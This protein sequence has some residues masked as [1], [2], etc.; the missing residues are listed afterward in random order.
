MPSFSLL[1]G[2]PSCDEQLPVDDVVETYAFHQFIDLR[3]E[4]DGNSRQIGVPV[5]VANPGYIRELR[6]AG[7]D[8]P[9]LLAEIRGDV[10][11]LK[12]AWP[13]PSDSDPDL[14]ERVEI[15][16]V[17]EVITAGEVAVGN[18]R[19]SLAGL[20]DVAED[21]KAGRSV[22]G[23]FVDNNGRPAE[24]EL[25]PLVNS[26]CDLPQRIRFSA[27]D[28]AA[29][30]PAR[31]VVVPGLGA[32]KLDLSEDERAAAL[33]DGY[34]TARARLPDSATDH[35][36]LVEVAQPMVRRSAMTAADADG[37]IEAGMALARD[38][39]GAEETKQVLNRR[40]LL[41]VPIEQEWRLKGYAR[42]MLVNTFSL[43]PQEQLTLEVF[44]WDRRKTAS[45]TTSSQEQESSSESVATQK[46][47]RDALR[48]A[49]DTNG[50]T[51]GANLSVSVPQVGMSAGT[52]FSLSSQ[53]E[54]TRRTTVQSINEATEKA[55][56]RIKSSVQ[57][58]VSE[59]AEFGRED[60][61]TRRIVNPN[62]GRI[63]HFDAF[64]VLAGFDVTTRYR[65]D[66]AVLCVLYP[67]VDFLA[68][69]TDPE[70]KVRSTALLALEGIIYDLV[71][72]R[73]RGGF[74]AARTFLAW[75]RICQYACDAACTC[76]T[77]K[78]E[79]T[80]APAASG[81]AYEADVIAALAALR[82]VIA[83]L[84]GAS[85]VPLSQRVGI[86]AV[87]PGYL[88]ADPQTQADLRRDWQAY[89]FRQVV[90]E[91]V[92]SPFWN[93]CNDFAR[94]SADSLDWAGQIVRGASPQVSNFMNGAIAYGSLGVQVAAFLAEQ[95]VKFRA[96][97]PF[98]VPYAGFDSMGLEPAFQRLSSAYEKWQETEDAR[99][100]P[101]PP[102][103]GGEAPKA[104]GP[105]PRPRRS[106]Q[107]AYSA[108]ALAKA[109]VDVDALAAYLTL[110]RA[111]FRS[112]IWNALNPTDRMR[113]LGIFGS[114]I[115]FATPRVLDFIGDEIAV[116][117]N[118]AEF[119]GGLECL[120][121]IR[122]NDNLAATAEMTLPVPGV[123]L[124]ARLDG[125]DLLEPYLRDS[126]AADLRRQGALADQ[127]EYE[128]KRYA[129]RI[130]S[131]LLDDPVDRSPRVELSQTQPPAP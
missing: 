28:L 23:R 67:C 126:R 85:G 37:R 36:I 109:A 81:N 117:M 86:P 122:K 119:P 4:D 66:R 7:V 103:A 48:E 125:C 12:G 113:F 44:S 127:V 114:N 82:A 111:L 99:R 71:P 59:A 29:L 63:L 84:N 1:K 45:E 98:M 77:P 74:D 75:D 101:A 15:E 8:S 53:S 110:N 112:A 55:A 104:E 21:L 106:D 97:L 76:E 27:G 38:R 31:G 78:P 47:T 88:D 51:F 121:A 80:T 72:Q 65:F 130:D 124:Q 41:Y 87:T 62:T 18:K 91:R 40:V 64:E 6:R 129:A 46:V 32:L 73:V 13:A 69:L 83:R 39:R 24:L 105:A 10:S 93:I 128:V 70:T 17:A 50:W 2:F 26:K 123:T 54:L 25:V 79:G 16:D 68:S 49:K 14:P 33:R 9:T 56:S 95:V 118:P 94:Q 89:L 116:E 35:E 3:I 61:S 34:V 30:T 57:T 58:K 22:Q 108:E 102:A 20:A 131:K 5:D 107:A 11:P 60:R 19:Y 96:N 120:F 100:E 52:N 115:S 43:A 90:M 42:G 92:A